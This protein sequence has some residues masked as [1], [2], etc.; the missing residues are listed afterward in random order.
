[1]SFLLDTNVISEW[2]KPQ[3]EANVVAWL[4]ELDEEEIFISIVSL[5]ELHQ[6]VGL[7]PAERR[8]V[9]LEER[10]HYWE[11]THYFQNPTGASRPRTLQL[12]VAGRELELLSGGGVF[13]HSRI[14]LGT[15][16]LLE[17]APAPPNEGDL[18]DLGCGYG[19]LTLAIA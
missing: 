11:V 5:A 15:R 13:G 3:P 4:A 16:V 18:L 2:V 10:L 19:P 7:L 1:M 6:G 12:K 8:R 17:A 9:Q 14:D